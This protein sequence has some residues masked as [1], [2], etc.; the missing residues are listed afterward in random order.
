M[1]NSLNKIKNE[2]NALY[3]QQYYQKNKEKIKLYKQQYFKKN[4]ANILLQRKEYRIKNRANILLIEKKYRIKNRANILLKH[5]EWYKKNKANIFLY[6]KK[7][8][9]KNEAS[10][11]SYKKRW[12]VINRVKNLLQQNRYTKLRRKTDIQFKLACALRSRLR[13]AIKNGA[14][15]GSAVRDL[16]CTIDELKIWIEKKFQPGMNWDNWANHGW[17]IDHKLA[18]T[19]FDLTNREQL[20]IA[21]HYTNLQ[22]MWWLENIRKSNKTDYGK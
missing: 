20:L 14:K 21:C 2:K 10:I 15:V 16:G 9:I 17:H 13:F 18:L 11:L 5:K 19:N 8:Y 22:P 3:K 6:N 4:R 12:E 7:Y 1:D